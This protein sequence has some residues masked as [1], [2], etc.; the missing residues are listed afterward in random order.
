LFGLPRGAHFHHP[1]RNATGLNFFRAHGRDGTI[2]GRIDDESRTTMRPFEV[3]DKAKGL[4]AAGKVDEL[5]TLINQFSMD[6]SKRR[7]AQSEWESTPPRKRLEMIAADAKR[8]GWTRNLE[9]ELYCV[10][11]PA[12]H[13]DNKA[14]AEAFPI[15]REL[16]KNPGTGTEIAAR[17]L[18]DIELLG[19][20]HTLIH[21]AKGEEY[22]MHVRLNALEQAA[23]TA[24]NWECFTTDKITT[25]LEDMAKNGPLKK[26]AKAMLE[27]A[28]AMIK[29]HEILR[30]DGA[31]KKDIQA[32]LD[33]M[34]K[35]GATIVLE[36]AVFHACHGTYGASVMGLET[37]KSMG[38]K[39]MRSIH[40]MV[41][42]ETTFLLSDEVMAIAKK[43]L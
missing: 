23:T 2:T 28:W 6:P 37:L 3:R 19:Y 41:N 13:G 32:Q 43:M 16:L 22:P 30:L 9:H 29:F 31:K 27:V 1:E 26:E 39:G 24:H 5:M 42:R 11:N 17:A 8:V 15:Y 10:F 14:S 25:A 34:K 18:A 4:Y 21:V 35:H 7:A 40:R 20:G 38:E 12:A 36:D 33:V